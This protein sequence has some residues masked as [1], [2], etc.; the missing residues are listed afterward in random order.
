MLSSAM[1]KTLDVKHGFANLTQA[2]LGLKNVPLPV[3]SI[4]CI[5]YLVRLGYHASRGV[6]PAR[7]V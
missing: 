3:Q 6:I 7:V 1:S 4:N 2:A 5:G